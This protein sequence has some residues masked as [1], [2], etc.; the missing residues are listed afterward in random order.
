MKYLDSEKQTAKEFNS[1]LKE[2]METGIILSREEDIKFM[3]E[4]AY[5]LNYYLT[6]FISAAQIYGKKENNNF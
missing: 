4:L 5:N 6:Y 3:I 2:G 1:I